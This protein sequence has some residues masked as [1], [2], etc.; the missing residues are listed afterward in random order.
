MYTK[1]VY[2]EKSMLDILNF[3]MIL[4]EMQIRL[5]V[6]FV[7][8]IILFAGIC[9]NLKCNRIEWKS[10]IEVFDGQML[11]TFCSSHRVAVINIIV[12]IQNSTMNM[13]KLSL[14]VFGWSL[15]LIFIEYW[16]GIGDLSM[17][18]TMIHRLWNYLQIILF[19]KRYKKVF[20]V[21]QGWIKLDGKYLN[22]VL[23][24]SKIR[25]YKYVKTY[26]RN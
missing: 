17:S 23:R 3:I 4:G 21:V 19:A 18:F 6:D 7:F 24:K 10:Y 5:E 25:S 15:H 9:S 26:L 22:R 20:W 12:A 1:V 13:K 16:K 11:V 8:V 14:H 2:D